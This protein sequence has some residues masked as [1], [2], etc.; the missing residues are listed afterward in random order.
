M[1]F[2]ELPD[3]VYHGTLSIHQESLL[4]G[5][6]VQKGYV[7]VDFG[8]GFYTTSDYE[9]AAAIAKSR[10]TQYKIRKNKINN[11]YPMIITYN[12][13]KKY[14][15][16]FKGLIFDSPSQNWKEFVYNN[17][18]VAYDKNRIISNYHN[19]NKKYAYVYGDVADS[20]ITEM[21]RNILSGRMTFGDFSDNLKSFEKKN[22][23]Q[24]SF[25]TQ[26]V[27]KALNIIDCSLIQ[28]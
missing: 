22:Y 4:K 25:H 2:N 15:S 14:L 13:N 19:A 8:Q 24:L 5:I 7:S 28:D 23:S 10:T 20:N 21:V 18:V 27:T 26:E 3:T 6:D 1:T 17:R 16:T 9:Q 12:I 11:V